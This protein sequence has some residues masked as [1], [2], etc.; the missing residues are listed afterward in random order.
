[1]NRTYGTQHLILTSAQ[2]SNIVG[3][4]QCPNLLSLVL[5]LGERIAGGYVSVVS[6]KLWV[7]RAW[8]DTCALAGYPRDYADR[9]IARLREA[10]IDR[11]PRTNLMLQGRF[12]DYPKRRGATQV[13]ELL[14]AGVNVA[15]GQDCVHD[16][17]R[18][19]GQNDQLEIGFLLRHASHMSQPGE[20]DTVMDMVMR[21][22]ARALR[23][24]LKSPT[25]V[26]RT[27]LS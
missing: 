15:C 20:I 26:L 6:V 1:M 17:F 10:N 18:P 22:G 13:K 27:S 3:Q 4:P 12:D 2:E 14:A 23:A 24:A 5:Q 11:Q 19:F 9:N 21:N 8:S 16:T 7:T 25:E